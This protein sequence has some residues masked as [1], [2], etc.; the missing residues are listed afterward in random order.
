MTGQG[1]IDDVGGITDTISSP[2]GTVTTRP[3]ISL[4]WN[5]T[6]AT[7]G[8]GTIV[9]SPPE[10]GLQSDGG[11][12][13]DPD[14]YL[15]IITVAPSA[16]TLGLGTINSGT[17]KG[18]VGDVYG[19][20]DLSSQ[21]PNVSGL[22][23]WN[24][25]SSTL[26][27][28]TSGSGNPTYFVARPK[29]DIPD[30]ETFNTAGPTLSVGTITSSPPEGDIQGDYRNGTAGAEGAWFIATWAPATPTLGVGTI[31]SSARGKGDITDPYTW[32]DAIF[33]FTSEPYPII[34]AESVD[35]AGS[36]TG[37]DMYRGV[38][39]A[40]SIFPAAALTS[41]QLFSSLVT[42][43]FWPAESF[44]VAGS[45]TSGTLTLVLVQYTNWPAEQ[46]SVAGSFTSGTLSLVLVQYTNWPAESINV[47]AALTGGSLS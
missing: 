5:K 34:Y 46:M 1:G 13:N 31:S 28:G 35:V 44:S 7:L 43:T 37:G 11:T 14:Q 38:S 39:Y 10:G 24:N 42:Y 21:D 3:L 19:S 16:P 23:A 30:P 18:D 2:V 12:S 27:L 45:F 26:G 17:G 25:T 47:A 22:I 32:Q 33:Y 40:E 20:P 8:L 15:A 9:S 6:S 29:G 36:F 41:G 4:T